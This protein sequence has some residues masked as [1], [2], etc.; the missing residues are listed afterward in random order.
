MPRRIKQA[1]RRMNAA[2]YLV[3]QI[4]R[5][6]KEMERR[7][8]RMRRWVK[9]M[10]RLKGQAP[11]RRRQMVRFTLAMKDACHGSACCQF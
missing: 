3:D 6:I 10:D 8:D 2:E 1:E 4:E 11:R 7:L 5:C 9:G